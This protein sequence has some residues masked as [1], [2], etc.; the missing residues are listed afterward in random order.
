MKTRLFIL[1]CVVT[2]SLLTMVT[3]TSNF[4]KAQEITEAFS[5]NLITSPVRTP[6]YGNWQVHPQPSPFSFTRI[7]AEYSLETQHVYILGGRLND[8][9]TDGSVWEFNPVTGVY[10]DTGVDMPTPVSN[11]QIA[12]VIDG[13]GDE[14]FVIFGSRPATG[15]TTTV[16]QGYYP[17]SNTVVTFASDPLPVSTAPGGVVVVDN[18]AYLFGGF[19]GVAVIDDTYIFDITASAG[20]RWTTGPNLNHARSYIGAAVIDGVIYAMGGDDFDGTSLIALPV[21]EKLDTANP[22]SW[23]DAGVA[24]MPIACDEAP[25]FGFDSNAGYDLANVFVLAG[26][27]QWS[28]EIAES[29]LYFVLSDTW[30]ITFPDLNQAR[31]NHAGA[32]VPAGDGTVQ[33]NPGMWLFGGRQGEDTI[34][35]NV[36]EYYSVTPLSDFTLSP[37]NQTVIGR[38]GWVTVTLAA[39]NLSGADETFDMSY[40]GTNSW[41]I[42]GPTTLAVPNDST[43]GFSFLVDMP[44]GISCTDFDDVTIE[45]TGQISPSL[46]DTALATVQADCF[47]GIQGTVI[48]ENTGLGVPDAYLYMELI[49]DTS[50]TY[51]T[52]AD[53]NGDYSFDVPFADYQLAVSAQGYRFT[54]LDGWLNPP[55]AVNQFITYD[56]VLSAPVMSWSANTFTATLLPNQTAVHTLVITNS[57]SSDLDFA[58]DTFGTDVLPPPPPTVPTAA[59]SGVPKVDPQILSDLAAEGTAEFIIMMADQADLSAAYVITDWETRGAYVYNTLVAHAA[60]SQAN[61]KTYLDNQGVT[62][63][64]FVSVNGLLVRGNTTLVNELAARPDVGYLVTNG[65]VA[66]ERPGLN[67]WQQTAVSPSTIEWGVALVNADD[68]WNTYGVTGTGIVVANIDSG[69]E[70]THDALENAYRGNDGDHNYN[71]YH[72]T[73]PAGCD[74]SAAPCDNDGHGTHTMGTMVGDDGGNNQIGVAPGA[75][76]VACKGC[77]GNSCS[78]EALLMCADWTLAPTDLNGLNP[79]PSQRPNIVNNSWGGSGGDFWYAGAVTAWRASGIFPQFSGGNRGPS[80]SVSGSPGDYGI[81]FSA[82]AVDINS[83]VAGFSSRG[84]A[85]VTGILKPDISGP[86]ASVRSSVPG[87][88]YALFSGTSM[89]SPHVAGV[90]ALL[91]AADPELVGQVDQTMWLLQQTATP[92]YTT[93]GCGGDTPTSHPNN[94]YGWGLVNAETAVSTSLSG[95]LTP[96]WVTVTPSGGVVAPGESITIEIVFS[97]PTMAGVYTGTL[98]LTADEPYNDQVDIPLELNVSGHV[99]FLP[100][101]MKPD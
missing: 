58:L 81:S 24:E 31:R 66:L 65:S 85:A 21:T 88:S 22:T 32:F 73:S 26:C 16:V 68:V 36:V 101:I 90:V 39:T 98:R 57:G 79:D 37:Q 15:G 11:Y 94:T 62:Y 60:S 56:V 44:P 45:A 4:S 80:C 38:P 92:L 33:G 18:L 99:L 46:T 52:F 87:N 17:S 55:V 28:S 14:V 96:P 91:W 25:G 49:T 100:V 53:E 41:L 35:L 67:G 75:T 9:N 34:V 77:E 93:D 8:G 89:A 7:D 30:D 10:T 19:D 2:V 82:A 64:T 84:P 95:D 27:G 42:T 69:V 83:V 71:W 40:S 54:L 47:A 23:D 51:D 12:R 59:E 76:W 86:G 70:W 5:P 50:V 20:S 3:L 48:D 74:G 61:I 63:Q 78:F 1:M 29:L 13:S 97:A 6:L 72:P 43:V